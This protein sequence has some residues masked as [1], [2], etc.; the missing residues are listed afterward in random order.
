[1]YLT[2]IQNLFKSTRKSSGSLEPTLDESTTD[3]DSADGLKSFDFEGARGLLYSVKNKE[4][5]IAAAKWMAQQLPLGMNEIVL[6]R[7]PFFSHLFT[8]PM[9]RASLRTSFVLTLL[10]ACFKAV[11]V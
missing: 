6:S 4:M 10:P 2:A 5:A 8:A 1:M 9:A 11:F 7:N 3:I